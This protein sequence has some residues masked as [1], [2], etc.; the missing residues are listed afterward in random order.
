MHSLPP[1]ESELGL[2]Y[3]PYSD[4]ATMV[5]VPPPL[6]LATA[7]INIG[8]TPSLETL[9][10]IAKTNNDIQHICENNNPYKLPDVPLQHIIG[11]DVNAQWEREISENAQ[12]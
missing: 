9:Q 3:V 7:D 11:D 8:I 2:N 10:A 12:V 4:V 6:P 5:T 1:H